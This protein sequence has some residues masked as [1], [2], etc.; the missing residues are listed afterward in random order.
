MGN[1]EILEGVT[2]DEAE[3]VTDEDDS[4]KNIAIVCTGIV[5]LVASIGA[6]IYTQK[7]K[8]KARRIQKLRSEGYTIIEPEYSPE[9]NIFEE[10]E[11]IQEFEGEI[12][13]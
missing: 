12:E 3:V 9:N 5:V 1:E 2:Y 13:K 4:V 8:I 7:D 10:T 6:L 11:D